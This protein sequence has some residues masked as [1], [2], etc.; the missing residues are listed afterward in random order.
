MTKQ[1]ERDHSL[2]QLVKT[3]HWKEF[4]AM[5][6]EDREDLREALEQ[7]ADLR[8]IA[9]LQGQCERINKILAIRTELAV[10]PEE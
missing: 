5:L 7:A 4:E 10:D 6:L 8:A 3:K 2:K 1:A 9:K